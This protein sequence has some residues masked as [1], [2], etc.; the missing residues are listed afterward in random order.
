M[1]DGNPNSGADQ[2]FAKLVLARLIRKNRDRV[3]MGRVIKRQP[4]YLCMSWWF[5][6]SREETRLAL[7]SVARHF[8]GVRFSNQGLFIPREYLDGFGGAGGSRCAK[9]PDAPPSDASASLPSLKAGN[10][11]DRGA[12]TQRRRSSRSPVPVVRPVL[13][14]GV[15]GAEGRELV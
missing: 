11:E 15:S 3:L 12:V 7:R 10:T 1:E 8:P 9:L 2:W 14:A 6:F 13:K 4:L 5:R